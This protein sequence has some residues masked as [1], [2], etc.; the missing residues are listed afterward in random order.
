MS[1][2][3]TFDHTIRCNGRWLCLV[4]T[5]LFVAGCE[6]DDIGDA[7]PQMVVPIPSGA[8]EEGD[9]LRAQASEIVEYS[10]EFPC[11]HSVCIATLGKTPYCSKE[12]SKDTHCPTAFECRS[13]MDMGPF[14][15]R[16]YCA[17]RQCVDAE[18]C[19]NPFEYSCE[20]SP[21]L[22]LGKNVGLCSFKN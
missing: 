13:V 9:V 3:N 5:G 4:V 2:L 7:C 10:V 20:H 22:S 12:C 15:N 11:E 1:N 6:S 16:E 17:W 14:S 21:E 19:G 8:T 18:D